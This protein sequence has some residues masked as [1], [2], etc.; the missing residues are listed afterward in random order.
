MPP[1]SSLLLT[2]LPW[3]LVVTTSTLAWPQIWT[4]CVRGRTEGLDLTSCLLN[5]L[6]SATWLTWG[7]LLADPLQIGV[8]SMTVAGNAAILAALLSRRSDARSAAALVRA[9][10][11][12][13]CLALL[14]IGPTSL[15]LVGLIGRSTAASVLG[16]AAVVF[17][18]IALV[19]QPMALLRDR[20]Q[21]VSGVSLGR[22]AL[23]ALAASLW[24]AYGILTGQA[25]VFLSSACGAV[26]AIV[27]LYCVVSAPRHAAVAPENEQPATRELLAVAA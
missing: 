25:T 7:L 26:S 11:L 27:V 20:K 2:V 14:V 22:F 5:P 15:T 3:I 10:P 24:T 21:D 18:F 17:T 9:L 6:L 12:P 19:P 23:T 16:F 13:A 4:S 8:N 1:S